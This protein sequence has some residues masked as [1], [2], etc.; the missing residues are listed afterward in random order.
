MISKKHLSIITLII[1]ITQCNA[2]LRIQIIIQRQFE[3]FLEGFRQ[4]TLAKLYRE[5]SGLNS[6]L[7][8]LKQRD[9]I[10][11]LY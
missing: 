10:D 6:K 2:R 5:H 8:I 1:V 3:W 9:T 7:S 4:K 11:L